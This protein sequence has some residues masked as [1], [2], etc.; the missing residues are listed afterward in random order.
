MWKEFVV[1]RVGN[2][3]AGNLSLERVLKFA[4]HDNVDASTNEQNTIR[5]LGGQTSQYLHILVFFPIAVAHRL[6]RGPKPGKRVGWF[7]HTLCHTHGR[8]A[9]LQFRPAD[10]H[11][12]VKYEKHAREYSAETWPVTPSPVEK[13]FGTK[14]E[15]SPPGTLTPARGHPTLGVPGAPR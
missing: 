10:Q 11:I 1:G 8:V 12:A 4:R 6:H 14:S 15:V 5:G 3:K 9:A 13:M 7:K 2:P